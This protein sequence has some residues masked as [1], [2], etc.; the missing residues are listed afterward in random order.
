M[1]PEYFT[2]DADR[3]AAL[4]AKVG[5]SLRP[6]RDVDRVAAVLAAAGGKLGDV[7]GKNDTVCLY[8]CFG[9]G[10]EVAL[11]DYAVPIMAHL[12]REGF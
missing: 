11:V 1:R 10:D 4:Q 12:K 8:A 6:E 3:F 5:F 7:V 2:Y 9:P